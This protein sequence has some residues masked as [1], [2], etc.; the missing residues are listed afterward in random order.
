MM[1]D[2]RRLLIF[3]A[4][5]VSIAALLVYCVTVGRGP[6]TSCRDDYDDATLLLD[7][8]VPLDD[9][10]V[11]VQLDVARSE[12]L[13]RHFLSH[14]IDLLGVSADNVV[15]FLH[16][17]KQSGGGEYAAEESLQLK[18]CMRTLHWFKIRDENIIRVSAEFSSC[19]RLEQDFV[20]LR[21]LNVVRRRQ[22]V[23]PLDIDE[24]LRV[25]GNDIQ[26]H[27]SRVA[28]R[29]H[30]YV[31]GRMIDRIA[32]GGELAKI[33]S[34]APLHRQFPLEC[35]L[36]RN[37]LDARS[38]KIVAHTGD[39]RTTT[40]HH[41]LFDHSE[42]VHFNYCIDSPTL[43]DALPAPASDVV[44][45]DDYEL[46]LDHYKW[47]AT[48]PEKL[49][50]RIADLQR[51]GVAWQRQPVLAL[52]HIDAHQ[53]RICVECKQ[54]ECAMANSLTTTVQRL[55]DLPI[56]RHRQSDKVLGKPFEL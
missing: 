48:L 15:V 54:L 37:V 36:T 42:L 8:L 39:L 18:R 20:A 35:R 12:P 17:R 6:L 56:R 28:R 49:H 1:M 5:C 16:I 30:Q 38:S 52:E 3:V 44:A 46:A 9:I 23:L 21:R 10:Y 51:T 7:A 47:D 53:G 50:N 14:Y 26:Q 4:T 11:L 34:D 41:E 33:R 32:Y 22:W 2:R 55:D 27:L 24:L 43:V 29:G 25:P 40:G 31:V 45:G 19:A 13:L